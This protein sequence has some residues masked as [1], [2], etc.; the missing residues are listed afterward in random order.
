MNDLMNEQENNV[1]LFNKAYLELN[2]VIDKK[3]MTNIQALAK[4]TLELAK[5]THYPH[6]VV[7]ALCS[8][9]NAYSTNGQLP[10]ALK[11][12]DEAFAIAK[13]LNSVEN[14]SEDI[15]ITDQDCTYEQLSV[16]VLFYKGIALLTA[17]PPQLKTVLEVYQQADAELRQMLDNQAKSESDTGFIND[18][19]YFYQLEG[20]RIQ[21][22]CQEQLSRPS[23]ALQSYAKAVTAAEKM[24]GDLRQKSALNLIGNNMLALCRKLGMKQEYKTVQE[25]M[26]GLLGTGWENAAPKTIE[27]F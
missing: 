20:L 5:A 9:A 25:K 2:E 17:K 11:A 16:Q 1:L 18:I 26:N 3:D 8:I 24:S 21:G 19:L 23:Q 7:S 27:N 13:N 15:A 22:Y 10:I 12:Y 14:L 4:T 6:L